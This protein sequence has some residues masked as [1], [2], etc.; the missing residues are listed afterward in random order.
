MKTLNTRTLVINHT[1][2]LILL[3]CKASVIGL[4]DEVN[5]A[6]NCGDIEIIRTLIKKN[7]DIIFKGQQL[8]II[9]TVFGGA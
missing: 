4:P 2:L 7:P 5:D 3:W 9:A 8:A 1:T 6:T